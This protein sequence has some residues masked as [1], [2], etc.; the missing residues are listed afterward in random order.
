M[1]GLCWHKWPKW[2]DIILRDPETKVQGGAGAILR[3]DGS[4]VGYYTIQERYCTKCNARAIR[5][6][7]VR[8]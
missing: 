1:I 6:T 7:T 2:D 4:C 3:S 8:I 5:R